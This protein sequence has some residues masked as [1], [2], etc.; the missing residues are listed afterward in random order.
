VA[1]QIN[2]KLGTNGTYQVIGFTTTGVTNFTDSTSLPT[3]QNVYRATALNYFGQSAYSAEISPPTIAFT[4]P[5]QD[6]TMS[7]I[8]VTNPLAVAVSDAFGTVTNVG[9]YAQGAL[10]GTKTSSPFSI[11]WVPSLVLTY[12]LT[13]E[14]F[15]SLGNSQWSLP[16]R[17]TVFPDTDGDGL[18]DY[19]EVG[20]GTDPTNS[21]D[22]PAP[23][24]NDHTPPNIFLT[25]PIGATPL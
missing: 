3:N 13:S 23:P 9:F 14:A 5:T 25:E 6:L 4:Y 11:N 22:P 1:F 24:A 10:A 8:G 15:D 18:G 19:Y 2:R 21:G 16:I 12:Q 20:T 17:L 7:A